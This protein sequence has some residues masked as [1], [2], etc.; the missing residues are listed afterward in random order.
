MGYRT[1]V[2]QAFGADAAKASSR[3]RAGGSETVAAALGTL[4]WHRRDTLLEA[5]AAAAKEL[6]RAPD[7]TVSLPKVAEEIGSATGVDRAHIFLVDGVDGN[8]QILE[9]YLWTQPGLPTPAEFKKPDHALGRG[10]A[11]RLDPAA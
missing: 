6:L 8:G 5:V 7:F 10:R 4:D 9:H 1:S 3:R 11:G 2:P